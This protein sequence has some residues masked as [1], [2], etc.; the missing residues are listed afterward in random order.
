M[1]WCNVHQHR[2]ESSFCRYCMGAPVVRQ[3]EG[4]PSTNV[5][6]TTAHL[7]ET[8]LNE[9]AHVRRHMDA[10]KNPKNR[11]DHVFNWEHADKHL[12]E[13]IDHQNRVMNH[14]E[15]HYPKEGGEIAVMKQL[16]ADPSKV[17]STHN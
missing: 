16:I 10:L 3:V 8:V 7:M 12:N 1:A 2:Y 6:V 14:V 4:K 17:P 9:L 11:A 15:K 5:P 13:A